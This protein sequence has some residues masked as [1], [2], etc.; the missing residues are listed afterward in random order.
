MLFSLFFVFLT[1]S[2]AAQECKPVAVGNPQAKLF[3][4]ES[5][6]LLYLQGT[7]IERARAMGELMRAGN[8]TPDVMTYFA[9]KVTET[10]KQKSRLLARPVELLYNQIVRLLHRQAPREISEE[11][12][13]MAQAMGVPSIDLKRALSLPDAAALTNVVGSVPLFRALPAAGC[14]SVAWKTPGGFTY[15]RNLDFA[16]TGVFDR[17]PLLTV[18]LPSSEDEQ[19]HIVFGADG[20]LFG[21]ITG[22]NEAGIGFAVHQNYTS[23]GRL[24]GVPMPLLGEMVLR[25]ARNLNEAVEILR[26]HRPAVLWTFVL[27]SLATGEAMT[28]ESSP[29]RFAVRSLEDGMLVQTNHVMDSEIRKDEFPSLGIK[30]NSIYRMKRAFELMNSAKPGTPP[31]T[32]VAEILAYQENPEGRLSAYHDVLKAHTIQTIFLEASPAGEQRALL[33]VDPAPTSGGRMAAFKLKDLWAA[34]PAP[35]FEL[36]DLVRTPPEKRERQRQ[37]SDAFSLY[38]DQ[39]NLSEASSL[40]TNHDTLDSA[41]FTAVTLTQRG[42]WQESL[43]TAEQALSNPRY[44]G[45]PAYIR[46]SLAWLKAAALLELGKMPEA[47]AAAEAI[48][49]ENPENVRLRDFAGMLSRGKIPPLYMRRFSF[50]FFSG[51]FHGRAN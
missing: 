4:C 27:T 31:L 50:D 47:T 11:I 45:E 7:P 39:H 15:G 2:A 37:I 44:L 46:Q 43:L 26:E 1:Q 8:I 30:M 14:T 32:T 5:L 10:V 40:L 41:F 12:D 38:F 28:V 35:S 20:V 17:H 36:T 24:S 51:D 21:G 49:L 18:I 34:S 33:S 22:V 3:Q 25:Q 16:S 42:L 13:A 9:G 29:T 48:L 19:K 6:H 23:A